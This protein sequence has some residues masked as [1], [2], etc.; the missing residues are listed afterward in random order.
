[1]NCKEYSIN[2]PKS[3]AAWKKF[4]KPHFKNSRLILGNGRTQKGGF[5]PIAAAFVPL[6]ADLIG[7]MIGRGKK[8]SKTKTKAIKT[9]RP[10]K[11]VTLICKLKR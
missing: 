8:K 1:M 3:V 10:L 5:F 9:S 2:K 4:K 11:R 6:A 7:K